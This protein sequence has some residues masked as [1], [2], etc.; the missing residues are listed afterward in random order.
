MPPAKSRGYLSVGSLQGRGG[1]A[2]CQQT[3]IHVPLDF[4]GGMVLDAKG[5]L[6][7]CD[8]DAPAVDVIARPYSKI[9]AA[10]IRLYASIP[11]YAQQG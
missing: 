9:T 11:H 7:V 8:E 3:E 6:I 5:K 1:L 2:G 10:R 4:A